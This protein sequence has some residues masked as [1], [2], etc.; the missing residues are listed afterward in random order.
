MSSQEHK[1]NQTEVELDVSIVGGVEGK[2]VYL[3]DYRIA[4]PKPWGGAVSN[5]TWKVPLKD[6]LEVRGVKTLIERERAEAYKRGV[7]DEV[8]CKIAFP[9]D[10]ELTKSGEQE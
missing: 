4:G 5:M 10:H 3:D 1:A 2:A 8:E 7:A 9:H 6:L